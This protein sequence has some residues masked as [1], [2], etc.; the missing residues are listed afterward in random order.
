[1][2]NGIAI[3]RIDGCFQALQLVT[4]IAYCGQQGANV[5]KLLKS[6][7]ELVDIYPTLMDRCELAGENKK[8]DIGYIPGGFSLKPL[9][10]DN[11]TDPWQGSQRALTAIGTDVVDYELLAQTF[12]YRTRDYRWIMY[13]DG[14]EDLYDIKN[15]PHECDN[16]VFDS[17]YD[18]IRKELREEV[19]RMIAI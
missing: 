12:S 3:A 14:S 19:L 8:S 16:L 18:Q 15:D 2:K 4:S 5:R 13:P 7:F 11:N 1:M 9:I 10:Q 17:K 6:I